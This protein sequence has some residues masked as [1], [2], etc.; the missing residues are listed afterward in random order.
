VCVQE[1]GYYKVSKYLMLLDNVIYM[2]LNIKYMFVNGYNQLHM[3]LYKVKYLP[4][5]YCVKKKI[6]FFENRARNEF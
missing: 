2:L 3:F 4:V 6:F 1:K 5:A